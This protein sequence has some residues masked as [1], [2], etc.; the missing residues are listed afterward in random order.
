MLCTWPET[1]ILCTYRCYAPLTYPLPG[2]VGER[3]GFELPK[4]LMH[5]LLDMPVKPQPS[6]LK[7]VDLQVDLTGSVQASVHVYDE[8]SNFPCMGQ[9]IKVKYPTFLPT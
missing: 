9:V 1:I 3:W 4:I 2:N 8:Q 7:Y 5:R 6:Y